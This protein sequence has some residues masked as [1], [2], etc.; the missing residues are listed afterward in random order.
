[1]V[2]HKRLRV[3]WFLGFVRQSVWTGEDARR[4]TREGSHPWVKLLLLFF[5]LAA[6]GFGLLDN[7]LLELLGDDVV[8]V[9]FHREAP[10]PWVM[11]VR[12]AP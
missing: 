4:C 6:L 11:E 5:Y 10:R 12:S 9:H 1:M 2:R 3:N 7:L 8:M